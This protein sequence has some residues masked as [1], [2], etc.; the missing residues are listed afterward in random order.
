MSELTAEQIEKQKASIEKMRGARGAMEDALS[1]ITSLERAL[2][3]AI[4]G[5]KDAKSFV[6]T[7]VYTYPMNGSAR[8]VHG[9]IDG[10]IAAAQ[11]VL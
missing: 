3:A 7:G 5:L 4:V 6:G 11:K 10:H 8:T 2:A 9:L 1:R